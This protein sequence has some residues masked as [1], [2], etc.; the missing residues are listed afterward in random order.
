MVGSSDVWE[1][2]L[3]QHIFIRSIS[4]HC[5]TKPRQEPDRMSSW[6]ID[7]NPNRSKCSYFSLG[8]RCECCSHPKQYKLCVFSGFKAILMDKASIASPV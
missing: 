8:V 5:Q 7:M 2:V 6:V 3:Q 4:I 1:Y